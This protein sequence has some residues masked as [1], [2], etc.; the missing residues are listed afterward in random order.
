[1]KTTLSF[2]GYFVAAVLLSAPFV[3]WGMV[4][5]LDAHNFEKIRDITMFSTLIL[6]GLAAFTLLNDYWCYEGRQDALFGQNLVTKATFTIAYRDID[7]VELKQKVYKNKRY[8]N[9]LVYHNG[10]QTKLKGIYI[11]EIEALYQ[12]LQDRIEK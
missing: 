11:N 3:F 6:S 8:H 1:M 5:N 7:K 10:T 12:F 4:M 2:S 9:I